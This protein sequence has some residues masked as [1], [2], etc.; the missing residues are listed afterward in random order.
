[1]PASAK[2]RSTTR[3]SKIICRRNWIGAEAKCRDLIRLRRGDVDARLLLA[4]VLRHADRRDEAAEQLDA[5]AKVEGSEKWALEMAM[6]RRS[7]DEARENANNSGIDE[8]SGDEPETLSMADHAARNTASEP[9]DATDGAAR[10]I[11][12]AA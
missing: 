6:E 8:G 2:K 3:R 4:T 12:N 9:S 10:V 5:L 7:L 11:R 1:M